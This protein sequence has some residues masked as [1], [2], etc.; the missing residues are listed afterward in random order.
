MPCG[1]VRVLVV[2]GPRGPG[3][4]RTANEGSRPCLS[5]PST[6]PPYPK[7]V[8]LP[9]MQDERHAPDTVFLV[10]ESDYR[11]YEAD[12]R[13]P[14]AFGDVHWRDIP[15]PEVP[16]DARPS[17]P[18]PAPTAPPG[19]FALPA[20]V[21][22]DL[23]D[24]LPGTRPS[25]V[26]AHPARP[27]PAPARTSVWHG[28][29]SSSAAP[30]PP[31]GATERLR[32]SVAGSCLCEE[33]LRTAEAQTL[34]QAHLGGWR[35]KTPLV[36][37]SQELLD[38]MAIVN[39]AHRLKRGNIVWLC[40]EGAT[41]QR[42]RKWMPCHGAT[43]LA[44]TVD[45]AKKLARHLATEEPSHLDVILSRWLME[46]GPEN[47][48]GACFVWPSCGSYAQ[49]MSGIENNLLRV[50][51]WRAKHVQE[52]FRPGKEKRWI[53]GFR[54]K[55]GPEWL[56]ET[57]YD[58]RDW[59]TT[60]PPVHWYSPSYFW[61]LRAREWI[62]DEGEWEGPWWKTSQWQRKDQKRT[63]R[64]RRRPSPV[65]EFRWGPS[66]SPERNPSPVP[67][68]DSPSPGPADRG[69]KPWVEDTFWED[70]VNDPD[71]FPRRQGRPGE[72]QPITRLALQLVVDHPDFNPNSKMDNRTL[73]LRRRAQNVYL[74][75]T[76]GEQHEARF[77]G[78]FGPSKPSR[79]SPA[80]SPF[81]PCV[82]AVLKRRRTVHGIGRSS[83]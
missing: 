49:H 39:Q 53:C 44:I 38:V 34:T 46:D 66:P 27:S 60:M 18:E 55:D 2:E 32:A 62:S 1:A 56:C 43:L 69:R 5:M 61:M 7:D 72:Q 36:E 8:A 17:P 58:Q 47:T 65:P 15:V 28:A 82:S 54:P 29:P 79:A 74:R 41:S 33:D 63:R 45:G 19:L 50:P 80:P 78:T 68:R 11:V 22:I 20:P 42:G 13:E 10:A 26:P 59:L 25:P 9:Y 35:A 24:G 57:V 14:W 52:G 40:W 73:R 83:S 76:F 75:R 64:Q 48:V 70:L 12:A 37:P 3:E 31:P 21:E 51:T 30:P 81:F 71:G 4:R 77:P 16:L 23:S 6:F 67:E